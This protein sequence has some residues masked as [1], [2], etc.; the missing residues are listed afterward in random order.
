MEV[1]RRKS[2]RSDCMAFGTD[3]FERLPIGSVTDAASLED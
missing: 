1:F 3:F 2:K